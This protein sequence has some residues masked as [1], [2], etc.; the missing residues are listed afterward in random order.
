MQLNM[1]IDTLKLIIKV[2]KKMNSSSE[3]NEKF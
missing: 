3:I 2:H 1:C